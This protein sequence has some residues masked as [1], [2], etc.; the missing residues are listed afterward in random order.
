M[1]LGD[2]VLSAQ[3]NYTCGIWAADCPVDTLPYEEA[4]TPATVQNKMPSQDQLRL[5]WAGSGL[6]FLRPLALSTRMWP[7]EA[8]RRQAGPPGLGGQAGRALPG[9]RPVPPHCDPAGEP[10]HLTF[11]FTKPTF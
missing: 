8:S 5:H 6:P 7:R 1:G 3:A 10:N 11:L 9:V 4:S 2:E